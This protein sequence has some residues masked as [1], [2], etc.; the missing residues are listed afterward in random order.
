M[1]RSSGFT[2][3][4]L[5]VVVAIIGILS[6]VGTLAYTGYVSGAK[7]SSAENYL[8]QISLA[9]T[10]IYSSTGQYYNAG[11]TASTDCSATSN[12]SSDIEDV[13]F[14]N[15]NGDYSDD[16]DQL[17]DDIDFEFCTYGDLGTTYTVK[18]QTTS[19][20]GCVLTL[21]KN[22]SI[23]KENCWYAKRCYIKT[24]FCS[25]PI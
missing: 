11:G 8:Q 21:S 23:E 22:G 1:T 10:E 2:L 5:L 6:A 20:D 19:G 24:W 16:P 9:Q 14:G 18:A 15:A 13:L 25:S 12:T 4:E 7:K 17:P 3:I